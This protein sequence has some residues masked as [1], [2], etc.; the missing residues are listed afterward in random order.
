[1]TLL[2]ELPV[3]FPPI[4]TFVSAPQLMLKWSA[5]TLLKAPPLAETILKH[6]L[7]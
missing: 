5:I 1:M 2:T 7:F 6:V 4:E 3:P